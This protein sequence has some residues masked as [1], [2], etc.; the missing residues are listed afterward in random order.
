MK[1]DASLARIE[2]RVKPEKG[3]YHVRGARLSQAWDLRADID[4]KLAPQ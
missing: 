2:D 3:A 1:S 4:F